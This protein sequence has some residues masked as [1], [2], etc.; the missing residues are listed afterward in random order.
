MPLGRVGS[1]FGAVGSS[2][3][4]AAA[5]HA[6]LLVEAA[7]FLLKGKLPILAELGGIGFGGWF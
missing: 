6:E 7:L 3:A 4:W 2:V 5:E 1:G